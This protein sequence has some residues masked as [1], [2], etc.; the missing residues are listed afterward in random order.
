MG[1]IFEFEATAKIL[2]LVWTLGQ[3]LA[4]SMPESWTLTKVEESP[5]FDA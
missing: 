3:E 1:V 2:I 4:K 5:V